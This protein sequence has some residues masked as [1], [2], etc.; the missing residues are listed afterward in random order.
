MDDALKETFQ[1]LAGHLDY[2]MFI[3]TTTDGLRKAGCLVGFVTQ[4]S[5]DPPRLMMFISNKNFTYRVLREAEAAAVHVV[6]EDAE[7]LARLFG[8]ETGDEID[9]FERCEWEPGPFGVPVLRGCG[10]LLVGRIVDRF[11]PP[12]ADHGGIVLEPVEVTAQ[13]GGFFRF[14][15]A[16]QRFEPGHE[17]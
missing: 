9:K 14:S 5:I 3:I 7:E 15:V 17:A 13:G 4:C 2:P 1:D 10:D 12:G 11:E 8:E 6:P 16:A